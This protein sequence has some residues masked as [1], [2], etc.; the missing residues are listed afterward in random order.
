MLSFAVSNCAVSPS[1]D[2]LFFTNNS[3]HKVL[4]LARDGT[5]HHTFTDPDLQFTAG[6]HVTAQGQV[7]V[8]G[9]VSH[10]I[11]QLDGKGKKKL[12][13]LATRKD[14]LCYPHAVCYNRSTVS[15]IVGQ[16]GCNRIL[17]FP[18]K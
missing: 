18:V 7:L 8:C 16:S 15:I 11:I 1:G 3:H 17:A 12:A 5:V 14:G 10:T 2:T 4:S 13:T 9:G 6:I